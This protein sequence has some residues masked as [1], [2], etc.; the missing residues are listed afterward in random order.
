AAPAR[1]SV[2]APA[3]P[4]PDSAGD[5]LGHPQAGAEG[6]ERWENFVYTEDGS[7]TTLLVPAEPGDYE[8]TYFMR[9]DRTPVTSVALTVT[10]L[11]TSITAPETAVIGSEIEVAWTGP[12]YEDDYIGIGKVGATSSGQWE[13]F[14]YTAA[15]SPATLRMPVEPGEYVVTYFVAQ[16]RTA[17]ASAPITLTALTTSVTGPATAVAGQSIEVAWTGPDYEGDYI[18]IGLVGATSSGQWDNFAYTED[19]SPLTLLTPPRAGEYEISYFVAQGRKKEAVTQITLSAPTATISAPSEAVQGSTIEI[20]WDGPAYDGDYIGIG[21]V[22]ATSS[23]QWENFIY[24]ED[25]SPA[26]IVIPPTSGDFELS[27]FIGQDRTKVMSVPISVTQVEVSMSP[28]ATVAAGSLM[29]VAWTGP[30]YDGDYLGLGVEGATSSGQWQSFAYTED[31]SPAK[32]Q[33][34]EVP[35][36]YVL[37]YFIAQD[38]TAV[39]E[40]VIEVQ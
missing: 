36:R 30:D 18:G 40:V 20:A 24:M 23:G 22:G 12:D 14:A 25:G 35:G 1:P 33:V 15:G 26:K 27:Y 39:S 17:L 3:W 21:R 6:T 31:G 38:R 9:Q 7:P 10:E 29:E 5:S 37:K 34:P 2:L 8:I 32:I 16:D 11:S 19:G 28:P 4:R 13:S